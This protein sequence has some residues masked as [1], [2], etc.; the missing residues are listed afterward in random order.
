MDLI[1][2]KCIPCEVGGSPF[3]QKEIEVFSRDLKDWEIVDNKKI[4]KTFN[5]KNFKE[6]MSF[7]NKVADIAESEGHHPDIYIYYDKVGIELS[8]HEVKGLTENDFIL[9]TKINHILG[10]VWQ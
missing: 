1:N 2:K 7:V 4:K 6:S 5:F 10:R 8:T 3:G 9:A